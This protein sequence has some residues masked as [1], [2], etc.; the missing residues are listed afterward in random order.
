MLVSVNVFRSG[1]DRFLSLRGPACRHNGNKI[2]MRL[3]LKMPTDFT[4][5]YQKLTTCSGGRKFYTSLKSCKTICPFSFIIILVPNF[6]AFMGPSYDIYLWEL[7]HCV[8]VGRGGGG[9]FK[10][11]G[12]YQ[13]NLSNIHRPDHRSPIVKY[14]MVMLKNPKSRNSFNFHLT[15]AW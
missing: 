3:R 1:K 11:A 2:S 4:R 12:P 8:C 9:S 7:V 6:N 5:K 10:L 14:R 15:P 13:R